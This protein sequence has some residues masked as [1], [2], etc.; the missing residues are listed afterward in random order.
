MLFKGIIIYKVSANLHSDMIYMELSKHTEVVLCTQSTE[1]REHG[2]L[3]LGNVIIIKLNAIDDIPNHLRNNPNYLHVGPTKLVKGFNDLSYACFKS[4]IKSGCQAMALNIEQYPWWVG[5]KGFFR[6][7][8]W[9]LIYNFF[10]CRKIKAI[11]CQGESGIKA[12]RKAFV[13]KKRM[14]EYMYCSPNVLNE[15]SSYPQLPDFQFTFIGQLTPRKCI[16]PIIQTLK[17]TNWDFKLNIIGKGEEEQDVKELIEDDPRF[18]LLGHKSIPEVQIILEQTDCLI[19]PSSF[20]GW[21]AVVSEALT[22]GCR[23]I[24]STGAGSHSLIRQT[25]YGKVFKLNDWKEFKT[26]AQTELLRGKLSIDERNEIKSF[27]QK[28]APKAIAE[29]LLNVINYYYNESSNEPK[30]T[31]PWKILK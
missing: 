2:T 22:H 18:L 5:I 26:C 7:L 23:C 13:H 15:N 30:P 9:C 28:I 24:V 6:R 21:G 8:Q 12:Y 20:D 4:A 25:N 16:L 11:G 1:F 10:L 31:A 27:G 17:S 19:L 29:Y 14:F 3:Q